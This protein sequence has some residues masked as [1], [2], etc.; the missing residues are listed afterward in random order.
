MLPND[1]PWVK[2]ASQYQPTGEKPFPMPTCRCEKCQIN[3]RSSNKRLI[4]PIT[5]YKNKKH[6]GIE[7][8]LYS[9]WDLEWQKPY[10]FYMLVIGFNKQHDACHFETVPIARDVVTNTFDNTLKIVSQGL[11]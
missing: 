4:G 2:N 3:I 8:R 6:L 7:W 9:I 1:N 5:P 10:P 11:H